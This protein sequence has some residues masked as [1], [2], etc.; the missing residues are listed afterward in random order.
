[1]AMRPSFLRGF[2]NG[3]L[4]I[5]FRADFKEALALL[6]DRA[7]IRCLGPHD[8][9]TAVA[10]FP[11]GLFAFFEDLLHFDILQQGAVAFFVGL[12]HSGHIPELLGQFGEAFVFGVLGEASVHVGP[13]VIFAIG[14]SGQVLG[15]IAQFT[16]SGKPLFGVFLFIP[17]GVF[18]DRR[19]L[20]KAFL[21]GGGEAEAFVALRA[22]EGGDADAL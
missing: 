3:L 1:M 4:L 15:G 12:F 19:D 11:D 9:V 22:G 6:A 18:K 5:I 2:P 13:F 21:T 14:G 8:Q 20:F 7:D 16:Q 10:A 17:G